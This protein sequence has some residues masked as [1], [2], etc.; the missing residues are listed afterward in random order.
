VAG[1]P[2]IEPLVKQAEGLSK[3]E[4]IL[5]MLSAQCGALIVVSLMTRPQSQGLLDPFFARL[6]TP[7]GREAEFAIA[8]PASPH[9]EDAILGLNGISL[10]YDQARELA[11]PWLQR[12]GIEI[13]RLT[14]FD[15]G[16]FLL[17]WGMVGGLIGLLAWLAR[18]GSA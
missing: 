1:W 11:Y 5:L 17:A 9:A 7:V 16:G 12:M 2:V 4:Q 18:L 3:P 10:N 14:I 15:W 6:L 13:P 8:P